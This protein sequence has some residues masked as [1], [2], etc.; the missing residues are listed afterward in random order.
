[1]EASTTSAVTMAP[2]NPISEAADAEQTHAIA[3]AMA[4]IAAAQAAVAT[5]QVAVEVVRLTRPFIFG[6]EHH[7]AV[8]IQTAFRGY[9]VSKKAIQFLIFCM[10]THVTI[11]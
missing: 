2:P 6:R 4:T 1:M 8:V 9:L 11:K 3:V 10:K 5:T 7:A